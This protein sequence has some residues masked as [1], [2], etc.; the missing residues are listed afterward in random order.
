MQSNY[1]K[2]GKYI[3]VVNKRNTD[4]KVE[5]LLGV[6]I[7]KVLMPSIANTVGTNMKTYKI[8]ETILLTVLLLLVMVIK[9]L[10][11]Y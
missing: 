3:Q 8:N 7:R 2:L 9:S 1:K 10:W 4:L 6:S 5:K 11:H